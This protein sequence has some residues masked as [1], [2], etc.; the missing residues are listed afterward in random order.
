MSLLNVEGISR[1][2]GEEWVLKN[3]SFSQ[4]ALQNLAI[5]GAT[6]SGKTSLLKIIAGLLQPGSGQVKFENVKVKGPSEKLLPGHPAIAYLSQHFELRSHYRVEEILQMANQFSNEEAQKIYEVCRIDHLLKRWSH[7]LSGG[8]KQRI[9][10]AKVL[11]SSP[12]LLLLDEPYSNLDVIHKN[13]LKKVIDD[14]DRE[15]KIT[16]ILVTHDPADMLSWAHRIIV[17]KNGEIVQQA[18]P[19]EIYRNPVNEYA[20]GLFG[21]YNLLPPQL[22]HAFASNPHKQLDAFLR[23][24]DF[25]IVPA[26]NGGVK[27]RVNKASFIGNGYEL[28]IFVEGNRIILYSKKPLQKNDEVYIRTSQMEN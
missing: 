9:A 4:G 21:K 26:G 25:K 24:E 8:E 22:V 18:S 13:L 23:P 17:L 1:R 6:G 20:A 12:K 10:L 27:G 3:I 2:E 11:V 5:A 19:E 28:E 16:C 15:L 7:Q 14:I